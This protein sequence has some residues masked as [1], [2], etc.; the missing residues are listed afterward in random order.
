MPQKRRHRSAGE[1][2]CIRGASHLRFDA[3]GLVDH[4]R[5]YWHA[6]EELHEKIPLPGGP[7]RMLKRAARR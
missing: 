4:H 1:E 2:R 7:M 6:A 5:D 3:D